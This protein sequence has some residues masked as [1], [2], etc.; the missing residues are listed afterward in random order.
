MANENVS[1]VVPLLKRPVNIMEEMGMPENLKS[2][3]KQEIDLQPFQIFK[4]AKTVFYFKLGI[5]NSEKA[6][7]LR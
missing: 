1:N 5:G 7:F 4:T 6:S 3:Q 2:R